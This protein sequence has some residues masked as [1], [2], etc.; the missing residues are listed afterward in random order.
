MPS[1]D[2]WRPLKTP[3][4]VSDVKLAA[5]PFGRLAATH[6][7]VTAGDTLLTMALAGSLFFSISPDAAKGKVA[8]YLALTMAPFAVVAPL[9]GPALDRSRG[10]RRLVLIGSAGARAVLCL[11]MADDINSL[12]LFPEAFLVL[13]ASK[14]YAIAKSALVPAAVESVDELVEAN[15]KLQL[16]GVAAG[17]AAAIPGVLIL[18]LADGAWVL[19]LAALVF[20][21][22]TV[23]A[24]RI[25]PADVSAPPPR[26]LE[27]AELRAA[28]IV[29]AAA[30][31][32]LL[33]ASVGFMTFLVAFGFR[34]EG[35]PSW[36]FGVVLA[37]SMGGTLVGASSAPGLRRSV[38]EERIITGALIGLAVVGLVC[39]V[40]GG[41]RKLWAAVLAGAVAVAAS[42]SKLAFDS[43][44]QRDAP[45]AARGRSFAR[46]ET[47]FQLLWVAGAFL[48]VALPI[49][50]WAGFLAIA[51]TAAFAAVSYVGGRRAT[52]RHPPP[53]RT[54]AGIGRTGDQ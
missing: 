28:G 45:D 3:S 6:G 19:R 35:A 30:A 46:F 40:R 34:N 42:V 18:Q 11:F 20:A 1:G 51:G 29:L 10:G 43:L 27:R 2:G 41:D 47:R 15:S 53:Q 31:M 38:R 23:L 32:G 8:L 21:A 7:V 4:R 33:R 17:L 36:W 14:T 13:V 26:D 37:A 49:P 39:G 9:L 48:P 16:L 5:S 44:V 50:L 52:R 24:F 25:K 54:G 12:L 22:G